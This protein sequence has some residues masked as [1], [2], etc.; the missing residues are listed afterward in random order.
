[1]DLVQ[2]NMTCRLFHSALL[3]NPEAW[4]V[5]RNRLY[6][7][8]APPAVTAAGQWSEAGYAHFLFGASSCL[9]CGRTC[10]GLPASFALRFRCCSSYCRQRI[11]NGFLVTS[12]THWTMMAAAKAE[13][14][15][16]LEVSKWFPVEHRG[17]P[18]ATSEASKEELAQAR[19]LD[20]GTVY[21]P[22]THRFFR[23]S[24]DELQ[25]EWA[26]RMDSM[27]YIVDNHFRLL[28]WLHRYNDPA[29]FTMIR[30]CNLDR[31]KA[32]TL[33]GTLN[34]EDAVRTPTVVK[35][36]DAFNRDRALIDL[37]ALM[38]LQADITRDLDVLRHCASSFSKPKLSLV[39]IKI[40]CSLCG[41]TPSDFVLHCQTRKFSAV[42]SGV[43]RP[44]GFR[45][46]ASS[47]TP[48]HA[49]HKGPAEPTALL[50]CLTKPH[51]YYFIDKI[52]LSIHSS[53]YTVSAADGM[54]FNQGVG[55]HVYAA[56]FLPLT[57]A[58]HCCS[59]V[60]LGLHD[61]RL[62]R[63]TCFVVLGKIYADV[64]NTFANIIEP[65]ANLLIVNMQLRAYRETMVVRIQ[66]LDIAR[67]VDLLGERL[68]RHHEPRTT[69]T[70]L[71]LRLTDAFV[72]AC[73]RRSRFDD[74]SIPHLIGNTTD[75]TD[76]AKISIAC[77]L[78]GVL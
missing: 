11:E 26:R 10:G 19:V 73:H 63:P 21:N 28:E 2:L 47:A 45:Q 52:S 9:V 50:S 48:E 56:S 49:I 40:Q 44:K 66:T 8:P 35:Y 58:T 24:V 78:L 16:V 1:M 41:E 62:L 77:M 17:V 53:S 33:L 65:P 18:R 34:F 42:P 30:D 23:R 15:D 69:I 70:I 67:L 72:D 14:Y 61:V 75:S 36:L 55:K 13:L 20:A 74:A 51:M 60:E 7:L 64:R 5:S 54:P 32:F 25:M 27:Q 29:S 43:D 4:A 68:W 39:E 38:L 22:E 57:A 76:T 31:V 3:A 6:R 12:L 37:N 71:T 46:M 59:H